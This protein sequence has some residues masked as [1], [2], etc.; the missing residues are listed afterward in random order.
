MLIIIFRWNVH[1]LGLN[2]DNNAND[3][4]PNSDLLKS[5][6]TIVTCLSNTKTTAENHFQVSHVLL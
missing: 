2:H 4:L 5:N 1:S 6:S 3:K